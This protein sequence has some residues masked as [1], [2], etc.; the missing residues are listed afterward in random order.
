MV[1]KRKRSSR[2]SSDKA[3]ERRRSAAAQP[4]DEDMDEIDAFHAQR[5]TV[6]LYGMEGS[7]GSEDEP[8]KEVMAVDGV[9]DGDNSS[10]SDSSSEEDEYAHLDPRILMRMNRNDESSSE[11]EDADQEEKFTSWGKNK[12]KFYKDEEVSDDDSVDE[13]DFARLE[14]EEAKRMQDA[15][16]QQ[17]KSSDFGEDLSSE[18]EDSGDDS[19]DDDELRAKYQKAAAALEAATLD[20]DMGMSSSDDSDSDSSESESESSEEVAKKGKKKA[21]KG[22]KE[23]EKKKKEKKKQGKA[24]VETLEKDISGLPLKEKLK[25]LETDAPELLVLLQDVK[26]KVDELRSNVQP[27]VRKV[28]AGDFPTSDGVSL[29]EV[30]YQ[31]LLSY[32]MSVAFYLL[33][34]AEGKQVKDHPV[35]A[36]LVKLRVMLD[37]IKPIDAKIRYQVEKLLSMDLDAP[38]GEE[39]GSGRAADPLHFKPNLDEM[40]DGSS[41][42]GEGGERRGEGVY[43]APK[44]ASAR[45]EDDEGK[46][47]KRKA[48]SKKDSAVQEYLR[49]TFSNEPE[50]VNVEG[51][52]LMEADADEEDRQR[53]EEEFFMRFNE[54]KEQRKKRAR[55]A[56]RTDFDDPIDYG[57]IAAFDGRDKASKEE[58][59]LERILKKSK[60]SSI[61]SNI[62][63]GAPASADGD[64][65]LP[66]AGYEEK[67][68][69]QERREQ[70]KRKR[71]ALTTGDLGLGAG[72]DDGDGFGDVDMEEDAFYEETK[73]ARKKRKMEKEER[74]R[75]EP[76]QYLDESVAPGDKR[77]VN[78]Q[79]EKNKGLRP[80]RAKKY[81]NPR[82]RYKTKADKAEKKHATMGARVRSQDGAY[83]GERGGISK[84]TVKRTKIT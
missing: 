80:H 6:R 40:G 38:A 28:R 74:A 19:E 79:I 13:E 54:T 35:I 23:Q 48:K 68:R 3:Q 26:A 9:E 52:K 7:D 21:T 5:D 53:Y 64:A 29:L 1:K 82:I 20:E 27:L 14:E 15:H 2:G 84:R 46:K 36:H 71:A 4:Q 51:S 39:T 49:H 61:I 78:Y 70:R 60:L 34:K 66:Y 45:Y 73:R 37:K 81:R 31:L 58:S 55:D 83:E 44:I 22:K 16:M 57:D 41:D 59:K 10:D 56:L 72:S 24:A 11:E 50:L 25:I 69:K 77:S 76:T 43:R 67:L 33:L 30:K 17:L 62:E 65:D 47:R 18:E 75:P 63:Q 32:C 12:R 42:E 8:M